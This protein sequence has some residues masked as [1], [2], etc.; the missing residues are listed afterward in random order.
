MQAVIELHA[1]PETVEK[2]QAVYTRLSASW[3]VAGP[4]GPR[5]A[6][7]KAYGLG[8]LTPQK[9]R[10]ALELCAAHDELREKLLTD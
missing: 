1:D 8:K 9:L 5:H 3:L 7:E 6:W 2:L 10:K 4:P